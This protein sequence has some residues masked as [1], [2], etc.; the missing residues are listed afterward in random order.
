M[1][2]PDTGATGGL[3]SPGAARAGQDPETGL[4]HPELAALFGAFEGEGF[5]WCVLRGETELIAPTGDVDLL[6]AVADL[7]RIRSIAQ[8]HGFAR[9]PAWGYGSHAFFLKYEESGGIWIKLDVVTELAFG[10]GFSLATGAEMECLARRQ[11]AHGIRVLADA[12]AFWALL[13]HRLLDKDGVIGTREATRLA[14]LAGAA[15]EDGPL[16]RFVASVCPPG[17]SPERIVDEVEQAHWAE[18]ARLAPGIAA[19]W[20]RRR[21]IDVFRRLVANGLWRW[22]G[23]WLGLIRRRGLGVALLGPDGAGKST[24]AAHIEG[25]FYFPVR[26]V[27][28]GLYQKPSQ[29][30]AGRG[31]PGVGLAGRLATQGIRWLK[32]AYHR[33]RGRLVLF[34]RYS[35]DALLPARNRQTRRIRVQRWLL[36]HSCPPPDLV[37]LL[38]AS[39]EVLYARKGEHSAAR[40]ER[41]REAYRT[42]LSRLPRTFVVDASRDP[43]HV[44]AEVTAA[45]WRAYVRRWNR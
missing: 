24:L 45:I 43:G 40:L 28:M 7:P 6:V 44:G 27:Y 26:S 3:R 35:Y 23:K 8:D 1:T 32:A 9:V 19:A 14:E 39:G 30:P 10:P 16:V 18:L 41:E 4:L 15:A 42:L 25:S 5:S 12:D 22:S 36:A 37:V 11:R 17:W 21:R 13:L 38:D 34:D 33:G 20:R 31:I 29:G 2:A